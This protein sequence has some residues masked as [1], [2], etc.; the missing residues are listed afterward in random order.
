MPR[1]VINPAD[2]QRHELK[3]VPEGFVVLR[4]MSYGKYLDRQTEAMAVQMQEKDGDRSLDMKMMGRKTALL[5]F[6]EC[7]VEHNL[8]DDQGNLL[9]FSK[10]HTLDILDPRVGQEI[11]DLLNELNNFQAE[12][13]K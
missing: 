13:G 12:L 1:A 8:E 10:P 4:R 11:G 6:K 9:D 2:T 7:I 5:E 3:T